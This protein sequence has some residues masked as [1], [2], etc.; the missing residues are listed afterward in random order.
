MNQP[1]SRSMFERA[2]KP[3]KR[4][5]TIKRRRVCLPCRG[6]RADR[7]ALIAFR[8]GDRSNCLPRIV[9]YER[10]RMKIDIE[11]LGVTKVWVDPEVVF[12]LF[13]SISGFE[14]CSRGKLFHAD[15]KLSLYS[16]P[17]ILRKAAC[18]GQEGA[19]A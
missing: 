4:L 3:R 2:Q 9:A 19:T 16:V 15:G 12:I 5:A 13:D 10:K 11:R 7:P 8:T 17:G 1:P 6:H 18:L 14:A